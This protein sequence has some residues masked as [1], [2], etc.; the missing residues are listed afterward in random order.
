[1]TGSSQ[2]CEVFLADARV[3]ANRVIGGLGE[4][5]RVAQTTLANERASAASG[6]GAGMILARSGEAGDLDRRVGKVVERSRLAAARNHNQI[7]AGAVPAK[8]MVGLARH[9]GRAHEPAL[10]QELARYHSQVRIN[11]WTMQRI[12]AAGG[13]LTGADGSIAKLTTSRICQVSRDLS[14]RIVGAAGLLEGPDSPMGGDLQAVNFASPGTRLGGGSDEIHL[15]VLGE[16]GCGLPREPGD[17][18]EIPYRDLR[19]GTQV[20]L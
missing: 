13:K 16:K 15:N 14:Y 1:M 9:Y 8:V 18:N 3:P 4:G 20:T 11:G 17:D 10:R 5:W 6:R 12:A 7:R 2:F 19:V